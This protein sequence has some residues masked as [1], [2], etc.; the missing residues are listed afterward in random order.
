MTTFRKIVSAGLVSAGM[1]IG[2]TLG[3]T[4]AAMAIDPGTYKIGWVA[5]R[6]G[7]V[8]FAGVSYAQGGQLAVEE[9]N[10][11]GK[12]GDGVK[13]EIVEREGAS[14]PAR[15][16]QGYNQLV[17]DREIIA[18]ACCIFSG[19]AGALKP[20]AKNNGVPLVF[21]GATMPNLPELP[22]IY[23]V[24]S[25]PGVQEVALS[26]YLVEVLKPK[27]VAYFV[28]AD[29]EA[30]QQRYKASRE[31]FEAAGAET[32]GVATALGHDTD[33]TAQATQLIALKPD[34]I[35]VYVTQIP[36]AGFI[37]AVRQRGWEGHMATNEA[38][39]PI[40]VWKKIGEALAGVP[41]SVAFT[42]DT[43]ETPPA[44]AF[45]ENYRKKFGADPDV[46]AAQ[47]YTAVQLIAQGLEK[48]QGKPTRE[49][50]AE[51]MASLNTIENDVFGGIKLVDGQLITD[52]N[53]FVAWTREGKIAPWKP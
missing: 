1:L 34:L 53:N 19:I 11:S 12:L 52:K 37:Q 42:A 21:Y 33:F 7:V 41:F 23:N 35:M 43:A 49:Q 26:K 46:Y 47:G 50:L 24:T 14:E 48:L 31:V 20:I 30:F 39:S 16:I 32:V 22:L 9:I 44:K 17:A 38:I 36:A 28:L 13:L 2:G 27:T 25:L 45:V 29:N 6:T 10:A 18:T 3:M 51:A 4:S 15:S 40:A 8:A 5:D